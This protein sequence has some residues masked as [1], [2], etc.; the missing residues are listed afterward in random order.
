[1][2]SQTIQFLSAE[3]DTVILM[4]LL[5]FIP[6]VDRLTATEVLL[7]MGS[8]E[9]S[10]TLCKASYATAASLAAEFVPPW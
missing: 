3:L 1:V 4:G 8:V 2:L 7:P 9:I 6:S 5:Q 10:Q